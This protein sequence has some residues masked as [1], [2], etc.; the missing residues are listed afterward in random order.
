MTEW[1]NCTSVEKAN[2]PDDQYGNQWYAATFD[3]GTESVL[4]LCK[5]EPGVGRVYGEFIQ[6]AK[7]AT[8]FR[9]CQPPEDAQ[10]QPPAKQQQRPDSTQ[11]PPQLPPI[12]S[13]ILG[14]WAASGMMTLDNALN[15]AALAVAAVKAAERAYAESAPQDGPTTYDKIRDYLDGI[16]PTS[17]PADKRKQ[18]EERILGYSELTTEQTDQL[19]AR[20]MTADELANLRSAAT[21]A[22]GEPDTPF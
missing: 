10:Q 11:H 17:L 15:C 4:W 6:T 14:H 20:L 13:N 19:L 22:E 7:G 9:K 12:V 8:R 2:I 21:A 1:H 3:G 5:S 18:I 16:E